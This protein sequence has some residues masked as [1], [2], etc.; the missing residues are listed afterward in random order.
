M[1]TEQSEGGPKSA[2]AS[3][4]GPR[5]AARAGNVLV[6]AAFLVG[7]IVLV[8]L[9]A[10]RAFTRLDLTEQKM[11]TI[12]AASKALVKNLP[13]YLNVTAYISEDLPPELKALGRYVRDTIDEYASA[14]TK[15]RWEAIDPGKD[16]AKKQQASSCQVDPLQIQVLREGKFEV[17]TYYLGLC[18]QYGDKSE[19]I[20]QI[21]R[22]EGL[23]YAVTSLVKKMTAG[24]KKIAFTTG[25]GEADPNQGLQ[26]LKESLEAE[27]DVVTVNPSSAR[28][29]D[30]VQAVIV[31][32]PKQSF[33]ETA[34]RELDRFL[35]TG[36]GAV[37]LVDGMAMTSPNMGGQFNMPG[38]PQIKMGQAN[39]HGL[40][41]LLEAYG[42]KVNQDFV[43]EPESNMLGPVAMG[44][45]MMVLNVPVYVVA[46]TDEHADLSVTTGLRGA[47]FPY[48]SS[49][50]LTGPLSGGAP[51]G[52]KLWRLAAS[53]RD[54]WRHTGFFILNPTT[55]IE[56]ATDSVRGP[57]S[58][59][60]AFEGPLRSAFAGSEPSA[61][62]DAVAPPT[63]Q[64]AKP[65]R[66]VVIADS[67]F[68][69]DE[70]VSLARHPLLSA[71]EMG[72]ALLF[73]AIGW[74]VEDETLTP[75]RNKTI[76]A[77]PIKVESEASANALKWGNVVGLPLAFCLF[78]AVRWRVRRARRANMKL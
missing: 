22:P 20:P 17:G 78:G 10:T 6:T 9:I 42:F 61:M 35:M 59:G 32:G 63:S 12:S 4:A 33:D 36:K 5:K 28:F 37:L 21:A 71:Y 65:V 16:D 52:A 13:D 1:A 25:H 46:A 39:E 67:D 11:Y 77:R 27:F 70:Y 60:Y 24:K 19:A 26:S 72:R 76:A 68:A 57:F 41:K 49:V 53:T 34:Q 48:V 2:S 69:N 8:N 18:L 45:R 73:N 7:G 47:V 51:S 54:A 29:E 30:D 3:P 50:E 23:E 56:P 66:L 40:G 15:F 75:L 43:F 64:S 62:S 74:T 58:F 38:Q 44:G 31:G 14:G 55:P